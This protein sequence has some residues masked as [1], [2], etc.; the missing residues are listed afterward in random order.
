[1][2]KFLVEFDEDLH[3]SIKSKAAELKISMNDAFI[4]AI[5]E[6]LEENN[7][8]SSHKGAGR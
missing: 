5:K 1:M 8:F 6:W 4:S 2:K 7:S 3:A